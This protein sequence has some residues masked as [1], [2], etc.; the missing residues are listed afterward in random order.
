MLERNEKYGKRGAAQEV[1][2]SFRN[3]IR[4]LG[5]FETHSGNQNYLTLFLNSMQYMEIFYKFRDFQSMNVQKLDND[6]Q[7]GPLCAYI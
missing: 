6:Q 4:I 3:H 2:M 1:H 7:N 5:S